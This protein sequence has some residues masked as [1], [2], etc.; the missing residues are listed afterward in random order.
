MVLLGGGGIVCQYE[1][2]VRVFN[3]NI[4]YTPTINNINCYH[5]HSTLVI[6]GS[7]FSPIGFNLIC[8]YFYLMIENVKEI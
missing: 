4:N 7:K 8:N 3:S 5:C 1:V 6:I 2:H